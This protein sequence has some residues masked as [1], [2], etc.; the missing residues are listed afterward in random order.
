VRVDQGVPAV[1]AME[2]PLFVCIRSD[3]NHVTEVEDRKICGLAVYVMQNDTDFV[4][5]ILP[6]L[7]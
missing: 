3:C 7:M 6:Y 2:V 1:S 4:D 5:V